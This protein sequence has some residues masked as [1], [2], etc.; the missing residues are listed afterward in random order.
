MRGPRAIYEGD[1]TDLIRSASDDA[2]ANPALA[3]QFGEIAVEI[4]G[5]G[6]QQFVVF[7]AVGREIGAGL[8][9]FVYGRAA[10]ART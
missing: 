5:Q 10:R 2:Q 9:L 4:S 7:A 1:R 6:D 3:S 8:I